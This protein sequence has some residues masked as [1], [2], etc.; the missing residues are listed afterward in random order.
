MDRR[1]FFRRLG[2]IERV[3]RPPGALLERIFSK[4]CTGCKACIAAC[5]RQILKFSSRDLPIIDF[6]SRGCTFCGRCAQSC[7][8]G[9]LDPAQDLRAAWKWRARITTRCLEAKG[10]TCRAC[11]ASCENDAFRF[12]PAPGGVII[13]FIDSNC[14]DGCG[15]CISGCPVNAI[16]MI[17]PDQDIT[18][19]KE[20]AA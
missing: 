7:E 12:R 13:A 2:G 17:E 6:T 20:T 5:P 18:R 4:N 14:C 19:R 10:I 15:E 1:D 16:A 3:M 8:H 9:A 11:E